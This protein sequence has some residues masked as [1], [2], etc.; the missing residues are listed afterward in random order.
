MRPNLAEAGDPGAIREVGI[1]ACDSVFHVLLSLEIGR[2]E[3][4]WTA[5]AQG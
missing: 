1:L 3:R 5:E 4:E 2:I